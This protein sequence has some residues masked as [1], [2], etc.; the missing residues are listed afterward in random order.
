VGRLVRRSRDP[1][2]GR[3]GEEEESLYQENSKNA[4]SLFAFGKGH[5]VGVNTVAI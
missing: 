5:D 2:L 3:Y 1:E 4:C